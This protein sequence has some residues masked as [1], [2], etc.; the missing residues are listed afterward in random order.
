MISMCLVLAALNAAAA[1]LEIPVTI[2]KNQF[3]P[4]EIKVKAGQPFVQ[5]VT[6]KGASPEE[7]ESRD[8]WQE[9]HLTK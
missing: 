7:F 9:G 1:D 3:Q 4:S 6:N 5:V 8:A 2:E